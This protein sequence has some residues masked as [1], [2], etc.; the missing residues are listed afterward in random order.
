[1]KKKII[2]LSAARKLAI[3]SQLLDSKA[4]LPKGKQ[5]VAQLIERLGYVQIDTISVVERSHNHT[6]WTRCPDYTNEML[7]ELQA[8]DRRIFEYWGHAASYLP[9]SDYRYYLP[10]MRYASDP[11]EKWEKQRMEKYGHLMRPVFEEI[12]KNGPMS[13]RDFEEKPGRKRGGWWDWRPTKVALELL[14][15]RGE[16]MVTERRNFQKVYDLTE[17]V[18][19]EWVDTTYP[20]DEELGR[21]LVK[22]ALT[23]YGIA[24]EREIRD[25]LHTPNKELIHKT[26]SEMLSSGE[27]I[28]VEVKGF[29]DCTYFTLP[30]IVTNLNEL[31]R[32]AAKVHILSPFDN[33]IIQR[34]RIN[35]LFGFDYALECYTPSD[36]RVYGYFTLPILWKDKLV[37]RL[38]PKAERKSKTFAIRNL[39]FEPGFDDYDRFL[40]KFVRKLSELARFNSCGDIRIDRVSPKSVKRKIDKLLE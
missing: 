16:I 22:R 4:K 9:M 2:S 28:T 24:Q 33:L 27:V 12:K 29:A 31:K 10:R 39:V 19:P 13:S 35:T 26:L 32:P 18:L 34:D 30:E 11:N 3:H 14:F 20:D 8:N 40:Q 5:G 25:H 15:W 7:H 38:D 23:S 1:M 37:G 36:K 17:R 6:I 21:F